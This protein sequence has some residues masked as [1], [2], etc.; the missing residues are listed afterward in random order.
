MFS[1]NKYIKITVIVLM[2]LPLVTGCGLKQGNTKAMRELNSPITL[3]Y[4]RVFD[5]PDAFSDVINAYRQL[6]PNINIEYRK[7]RYDEYEQALLE[8]WAEDRG[9]DIFTI[10]NTWLSKYE[11]KILPIPDKLELPYVIERDKK[12]GEVIKADYRQAKVLTPI[13]VRNNFAEVVYGDVVR[14]NKIIGLPLSVDTLALFYNRTALDNAQITK[15][16]T[17]WLEIKEAVKKLTL[18]NDEGEIIQSGIA[19]GTAENINRVADIVS[20]LMMQ[21]GAQMTD[22][23]GYKAIFNKASSYTGSQDYRPGMEALRFYTD[24][25]LPSKEVYNWNEDMPEASQSFVQG[26]VA[27][28]LGYSYQLPLIRTQGAKL[29]LGIAEVPHINTNQTDALG[30]KVNMASYWVEVVAKKTEHENYAWDFIQ[31]ITKADQVTKYLKKTKK[32]T[33]LRSLINEQL[34]DYDIRPFAN[35]VLTAKSWYKGRQA[36]VVEDIFKKMISVVID[37]KNTAEEA[38]N[39]AASQVNRTF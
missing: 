13:D 11:S 7:F 36:T 25:A 9:P 28:M 17:T 33:A 26:K 15:V 30:N 20:L 22:T 14:N 6:H 5:G 29:N 10:H 23:S 34:A 32:P 24:F 8:A 18:Q 27:M 3:K 2:L 12:S 31:F 21:N 16:P 39:F 19:L 4:W 35:Q 1:K 37:G 38:I